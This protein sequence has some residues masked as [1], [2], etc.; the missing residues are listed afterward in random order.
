[1]PSSHSILPVV[2]EQPKNLPIATLETNDKN[3]NDNDNDN[4][5]EETKETLETETQMG[6]SGCN[7]FCP[8]DPENQQQLSLE[9][10]Q[11]CN[12]LVKTTVPI[13]ATRTCFHCGQQGHM[14]AQCLR[15]QDQLEQ[16]LEGK[17]AFEI[18]VDGGSKQQPCMPQKNYTLYHFYKLQRWVRIQLRQQQKQQHSK[19]ECPTHIIDPICMAY[20]SLTL[21]N[22]NDSN[23]Y[24]Y[25]HIHIPNQND[26]NQQRRGLRK[27]MFHSYRELFDR[28][29]Q[30][31]EIRYK[32][33]IQ[34]QQQQ[35]QQQHG[36]SQ[37]I[38][39]GLPDPRI[40]DPT[41]TLIA[42]NRASS[43]CWQA[44]LTQAVKDGTPPEFSDPASLREYTVQKLIPRCRQL[45]HLI[46]D[47]N[48]PFASAIRAL[49]L[50]IQPTKQASK[51]TSCSNTSNDDD[52]DHDIDIPKSVISVCSIGGGPGFDHIAICMVATFLHS[53]VAPS[54]DHQQ[55][56]QQ[57]EEQHSHD[58][59]CPMIHTRVFDLWND[60][61]SPIANELMDCWKIGDPPVLLEPSSQIAADNR[62]SN[63]SPESSLPP[64]RHRRHH[65]CMTM[66]HADLR[67]S[68]QE[69][70]NIE[71]KNAIPNADVIVFQFVL[72]ENAVFLQSSPPQLSVTSTDK[73]Q[74]KEE[75]DA[76]TA[77][78][79]E[80]NLVS[81][82]VSLSIPS[83]KSQVMLSPN[84]AVVGVLQAAKL[85]AII[86]CTDSVH[87]LWPSL[88]LTAKLHGWVS[89]SKAE[90]SHNI[91][92]GPNSYL[93]LQRM[94][95]QHQ[96]GVYT[97]EVIP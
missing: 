22:S 16:S 70:S 95:D 23:I 85:G 2:Q 19:V 6:I 63:P 37:L 14:A 32:G 89:M 39:K 52:H 74:D 12:L 10:N 58:N 38:P 8:D 45:H 78:N 44:I 56:Q 47:H 96:N 3:D 31:L 94:S 35:Q 57:E 86:V 29:I 73:E 97:E 33:L 21:N 1:M 61:W 84:N 28:S 34:H 27:N 15:R 41:S 62:Y 48:N 65:H 80:G 46:L 71:L 64:I 43:S 53:I 60:A 40:T 17:V 13:T 93:L 88:Q 49:L 83:S 69:S 18:Y 11:R 24:M 51:Q 54:H 26:Q 82:D 55:H 76:N 30:Q 4:D 66:H 42:N 90:R 91:V 59:V 77:V 79:D 92:M 50:R 25:M 5:T 87:T 81:I 36:N 7:D 72:H 67:K 68:L 20:S 9:I 75:C